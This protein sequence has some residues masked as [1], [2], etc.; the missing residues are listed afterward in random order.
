M[1]ALPGVTVC[2]C[3]TCR[4]SGKAAFEGWGEPVSEQQG[5]A[6]RALLSDLKGALGRLQAATSQALRGGMKAAGRKLTVADQMM[7]DAAIR[8]YYREVIDGY[9]TSGSPTREQFTSADAILPGHLR[10]EYNAGVDAAVELLGEETARVVGAART[11]TLSLFM[12]DAFSRLSQRGWGCLRDV[13]DR[14]GDVRGWLDGTVA[15]SPG[16]RQIIAY[17][18]EQG[19]NPLEVER[20]CGRAYDQYERWEFQRLARTEIAFATAAGQQDELEAAGYRLVP[21]ANGDPLFRVPIH[22]NCICGYSIDIATKAIVL[23]LASTACQVCIDVKAQETA[24]LAELAGV[25]TGGS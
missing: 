6:E 9:A 20:W 19:T 11:R 2:T 23:N 8:A 15:R 21:Q 4:A 7:L 3:A 14:D 22:P 24:R 5:R 16:V 18:V 25:N 17:G 13:M 12:R 1:A 10:T